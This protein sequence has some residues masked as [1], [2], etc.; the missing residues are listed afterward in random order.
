MQDIAS[1]RANSGPGLVFDPFAIGQ[2]HT[3]HSESTSIIEL[4]ESGKIFCP[5]CLKEKSQ[6]DLEKVDSAVFNVYVFNLF[7]ALDQNS[8]NSQLRKIAL[9]LLDI[10]LEKRPIYLDS[11]LRFHNILRTIHKVMK[12]DMF[13]CGEFHC[14]AKIFSNISGYYIDSNPL[15][16]ISVW[17]ASENLLRQATKKLTPTSNGS[18]ES[19]PISY[20]Y[21]GSLALIIKTYLKL[22]RRFAADQ[23][24][25]LIFPIY[26]GDTPIK[27]NRSYYIASQLDCLRFMSETLLPKC[28][29]LLSTIDRPLE[30]E[31]NFMAGEMFESLR[32]CFES[33]VRLKNENFILEIIRLDCI[34]VAHSIISKNPCAELKAKIKSYLAKFVY[35]YV[36][37]YFESD[38]HLKS[39]ESHHDI[40]E[41]NHRNAIARAQDR[42][43]YQKTV[44]YLMVNAVASRQKSNYLIP[45]RVNRVLKLVKPDWLD[46][47]NSVVF[48]R[49]YCYLA[50]KMAIKRSKYENVD[51]FIAQTWNNPEDLDVRENLTEIYCYDD[52]IFLWVHGDLEFQKTVSVETI[53][54]IVERGAKKDNIEKSINLLMGVDCYKSLLRIYLRDEED[55]SRMIE[56]ILL[57]DQPNRTESQDHLTVVNKLSAILPALLHDAILDLNNRTD[58]MGN[59]PNIERLLTMNIAMLTKCKHFNI[60]LD[61]Q[62]IIDLF[63]LMERMYSDE[64]HSFDY[65]LIIYNEFITLMI[66]TNNESLMK[67]IKYLN[68]NALGYMV[69]RLTNSTKVDELIESIAGLFVAYDNLDYPLA[70]NLVRD[71]SPTSMSVYSWMMSRSENLQSLALRFAPKVLSRELKRSEK[72]CIMLGLAH[73]LYRSPY[74]IRSRANWEFITPIMKLES[75]RY[76]PLICHIAHLFPD[77]VQQEIIGPSE[78]SE[79][80]SQSPMSFASSEDSVFEEEQISVTRILTQLNE[81][82][83][84]DS[85]YRI[86]DVL[87]VS[88][89]VEDQHSSSFDMDD[90]IR[91]ALNST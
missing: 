59:L 83:R 62:F 22:L 69:H 21:F 44:F 28:W 7:E 66:K 50:A 64:T 11:D 77:T 74:L 75:F 51:N 41:T 76:N 25:D 39:Y 53:K 8:E 33:S 18:Q 65:L 61:E 15:P 85:S 70:N 1:S 81:E 36:E 89:A 40:V 20:S 6:K 78:D 27:H 56:K 91:R 4:E 16:L 67:V 19:I 47:R 29:P 14:I 9:P 17:K 84:P 12:S 55:A 73:M 13:D 88:R 72:T 52:T 58:N 43:K 82:E 80:V 79:V 26:E 86:P 34:Q 10:I 63:R 54:Y 23:V 37:E 2:D 68:F 42:D 57:A 87:F 90:W 24:S 32:E 71:L 48:M 3:R 45:Q 60:I 30:P 5:L 46:I 38:E 35:H 31:E 49:T